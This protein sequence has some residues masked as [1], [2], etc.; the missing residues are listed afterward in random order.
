MELVAGSQWRTPAAAKI[1]AS[2]GKNVWYFIVAVDSHGNFDREPEIGSGAFQYY[3]QPA[4]ACLTT[5]RPPVLTGTSSGT[6]VTLNWTAPIANT[7]GS[8]YI[9][10]KGFRVYRSKDLAALCAGVDDHRQEH[11]DLHRHARRSRNRLVPLLRHRLRSV[12][13]DTQGQRRV[14]LLHRDGGGCL[15][16]HPERPDAIRDHQ[17]EHRLRRRHRHAHVDGAGEEHHR[18]RLHRPGRLPDLEA[19]RTGANTLY[20]PGAGGASDLSPGTLSF[21][22][23]PTGT[24]ADLLTEDYKYYV[25]AFDTCTTPGEKVSPLSPPLH[26]RVHHT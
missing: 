4:D 16:Q 20:V 21:T 2:D 10:A 9:D 19:D 17:R 6:T 24:I 11:A 13:P 7:N 5:P 14:E 23:P 18:H 8:S 15:Q 12:P 26:R 3:Q 22:D 25:T 1:P